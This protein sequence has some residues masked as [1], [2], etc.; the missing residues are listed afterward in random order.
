MQLASFSSPSDI[1]R[2]RHDNYYL[3]MNGI[4]SPRCVTHHTNHS[5][6]QKIGVQHQ[7]PLY[8]TFHSLHKMRHLEG[9]WNRE[10]FRIINLSPSL[11]ARRSQHSRR[12][13]CYKE[14][15]KYTLFDYPKRGVKHGG[16][17]REGG[18]GEIKAQSDICAPRV[19]LLFTPALS[20]R[21]SF[22]ALGL[23]PRVSD[24][25]LVRLPCCFIL[26][27]SYVMMKSSCAGFCP[28]PPAISAFSCVQLPFVRP[29]SVALCRA[30]EYT[31]ICLLTHTDARALNPRYTCAE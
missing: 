6:W 25:A 31:L 29:R 23:R 17:W 11:A 8:C 15:G 18:A 3:H 20:A 30:T 19:R 13:V 2:A 9:L 4:A 24:L 12:N 22:V 26:I 28:S 5:K 14:L 10:R 16:G 7:A 21:S 1:E 27:P